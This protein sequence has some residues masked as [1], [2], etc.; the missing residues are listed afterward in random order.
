MLSREF[1]VP[2][3]V[4]EIGPS[5]MM[6]YFDERRRMMT[7]HN[8]SVR[9]AVIKDTNAIRNRTRGDGVV[10]CPDCQE[11]VA[12]GNLLPH[13]LELCSAKRV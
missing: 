2:A 11:E 8:E 1:P 3:F 9:Q 12:W 4:R 10:M 7:A 5:G 6:F 13:R